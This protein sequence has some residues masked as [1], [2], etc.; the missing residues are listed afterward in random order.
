M[1]PNLFSRTVTLSFVIFYLSLFSCTN[2]NSPNLPEKKLMALVEALQLQTPKEG[3]F[4]AGDREIPQG[5]KNLPVRLETPAPIRIDIVA[6]MQNVKDITLR[7][8]A[9]DITY[10]KLEDIP[11]FV[12]QVRPQVQYPTSL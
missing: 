2:R 1:S 12:Y 6:G 10:V 8:I 3:G 7:E 4:S 5:T 11:A 9:S